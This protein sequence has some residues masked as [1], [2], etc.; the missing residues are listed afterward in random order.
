MNWSTMKGDDRKRFCSA[1]ELNVYN[2][3]DMTREEATKLIEQAEGRLCVRYYQ[4]ADGTV[5]TQN[6]PVGKSAL[7]R[8]VSKLCVGGVFALL[9][10]LGSIWAAF[11]PQEKRQDFEVVERLRGVPV[12]GRVVNKLYPPTIVGVVPMMG[13]P[14]A[15]PP[16]P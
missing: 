9:T 13:K 11:L 1:C 15:P 4:R 5:L 2:L 16:I 12:V 10:G 6:C 7:M 8:R 3:S 14:M